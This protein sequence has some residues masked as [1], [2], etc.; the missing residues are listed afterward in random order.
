LLLL[1]LL[2]LT[3]C[4]SVATSLPPAHA[5]S[6]QRAPLGWL[7]SVGGEAGRIVFGVR[8]FE[9]TR[10]G[11]RA[12]V[13]LANDTAVPFGVGNAALPG[14]RQF[15]LMLFSTGTHSELETRNAK[16]SLPTIRLAE[17]FD[18]ALPAVLQPHRTWTGTIGARGPLAAG[19]WVRIVF[20]A[21]FPGQRIESGRLLP[22]NPVVP[23]SLRKAN[24]GSDLIWIT[25]HAHKLKP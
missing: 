14:S 17:A 13:T 6:P 15:G 11:W 3:G 7:E 2:V 21:L 25:D 10:D 20:G 18:P 8:T 4:G 12:D 19:T 9:V 22:S 16:A 5:A 23:D 24:I 1:L